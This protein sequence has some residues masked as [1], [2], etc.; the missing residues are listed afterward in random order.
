MVISIGINMGKLRMA[1]IDGVLFALEATA[2]ISVRVAARPELPKRSPKINIQ[3]SLTSLP[4][5]SE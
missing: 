1:I 4:R 2:E 5:K 3:V